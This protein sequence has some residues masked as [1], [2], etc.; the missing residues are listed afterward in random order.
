M[1]VK[2]APFCNFREPFFK[3]G[4]PRKGSPNPKA[5]EYFL[6]LAGHSGQLRKPGPKLLEN[7]ECLSGEKMTQTKKRKA[8]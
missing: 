7:P 8:M 5:I 4:Y 1:R 2:W 3:K 6:R